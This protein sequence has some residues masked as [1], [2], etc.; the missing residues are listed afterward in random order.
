MPFLDV[1]VRSVMPPSQEAQTAKP[2]S[3]I[4]PVTT[5]GASARG[6]L[7]FSVAWTASKSARSMIGGTAM[8]MCSAAGFCRSVFDSRLL[9][10]HSPT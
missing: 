6:F 10:T 8:M 2:V 3:R 7:A 9:K 4:G 1:P 5:R